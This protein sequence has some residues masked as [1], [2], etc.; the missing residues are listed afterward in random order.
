V[1]KKILVIEDEEK[2]SDV[3]SSYLEKS[4]YTPVATTMGEE[5][6]ALA[7]AETPVLIIL[8]LM[9]P[10]ISGEEVCKRI[11]EFAS[12]PIIMLTAKVDEGDKLAGFESGADDYV[13]K[14]F[15][16]RVLLARVE[17]VLRRVGAAPAEVPESKQFCDGKINI[18][19]RLRQVLVENREID[20]TPNEYLLLLSLLTEPGRIFSRNDLGEIL[21]SGKQAPKGRIVDTYIKTIRKKIESNPA[22]PRYIRTV[23][24]IGY[25]FTGTQD[26]PDP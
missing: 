7:K 3:I 14:P 10:D 2:I 12:V 8:D 6:L 18:N 25:K 21:S 24:G 11:R 23:H 1:N 4:G 5:G 16:P 13:T 15:S 20:L 26:A 9:L 19:T 22:A 17:A